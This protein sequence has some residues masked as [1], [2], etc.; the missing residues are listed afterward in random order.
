MNDH[1]AMEAVNAV[2]EQFFDGEFDTAGALNRIAQI[3]DENKISHSEAKDAQ[4]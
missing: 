4:K 2:L 1:D 3:S